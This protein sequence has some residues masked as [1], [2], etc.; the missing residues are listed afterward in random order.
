M[1]ISRQVRHDRTERKLQD[2]DCQGHEIEVIH[3]SKEDVARKLAEFEVKYGMTSKE[4]I[5]KYN[6]C[7]FRE[8]NLEFMDWVW[9]YDV[10][11]DFGMVSLELGR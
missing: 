4:F 6:S 5:T 11:A 3:E 2:K 1:P 9:Y 8:E 7:Q 10:A